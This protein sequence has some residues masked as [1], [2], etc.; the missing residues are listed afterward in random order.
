MSS[1]QRG[2]GPAEKNCYFFFTYNLTRS[3]RGGTI[4]GTKMRDYYLKYYS[5]LDFYLEMLL[6]LLLLSVLK[7]LSVVKL[8][9]FQ[10]S[11]FQDNHIHLFLDAT[12]VPERIEIMSRLHYNIL[13]IYCNHPVQ[14]DIWFVLDRGPYTHYLIFIC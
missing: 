7:L 3:I 14:E 8:M 10:Y 6:I 5:V 12:K 9:L 1:I 2:S 11:N 4:V 13:Y